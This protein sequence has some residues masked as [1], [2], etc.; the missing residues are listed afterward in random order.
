MIVSVQ[1]PVN[2]LDLAAR[3]ATKMLQSGTCRVN[4]GPTPLQFQL[5]QSRVDV[6]MQCRKHQVDMLC[7]M[8]GKMI[9]FRA[10]HVLYIRRAVAID[11]VLCLQKSFRF[12]DRDIR[13]YPTPRVTKMGSGRYNAFREKPFSHSCN[14]EF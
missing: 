5:L 13:L 10:R 1:M 3:F 2:Y 8:L 6:E 4:A 12:G 14:G 11:V 7:D 9:P